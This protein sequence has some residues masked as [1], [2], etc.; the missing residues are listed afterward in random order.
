MKKSGLHVVKII[1][2][3]K[4]GSAVESFQFVAFAYGL[5]RDLGEAAIV[6]RVS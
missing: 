3:A 5:L 4:E 2:A 6:D 1:D